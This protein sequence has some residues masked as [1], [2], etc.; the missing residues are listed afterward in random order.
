MTDPTPHPL[1]FFEKEELISYTNAL[2][3]NA[4]SCLMTGNVAGAAWR[5]ADALV[6]LGFACPPDTAGIDRHT[7]LGF[8]LNRIEAM[9]ATPTTSSVEEDI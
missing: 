1:G 5:L 9:E 2:L 6:A 3:D 8:R 4:K 7:G